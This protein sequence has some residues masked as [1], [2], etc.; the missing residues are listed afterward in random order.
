[1]SLNPHL[2]AITA[3]EI[4][5]DTLG[6][7]LMESI[8]RVDPEARFIGIGGPKMIKAGMVS[9]CD[10]K[11]LSVMGIT[12]VLSH[13]VPILKVRNKVCKLIIK[14]RPCV[15][16]GIDSPDFNLTLERRVRKSGIP[17]VHY[18]SPSVWAWREGR[19]KT[20]RQSCDEVLCL[21][22]FEKDFYD[23]KGMAATYVGHALANSIPISTKMETSRERVDLYRTSV[24][25]I[26]GRVMGILPGSRNGVIEH[27]LPVYAQAA[28]IIKQ[29]SPTTVF[30]STV[31]TYELAC[32]V[33]DL[34]LA[35]AP[36][37]SITVY[38]GSTRDVIASCDCL[39]LTSGTIALET[40]LINRP[41][42]VA[43]K[44]S[45]L[46]AAIGRRM[47]R[48]STYSLPNLIANT[49]LVKE[50]IQEDCTP[51]ALASEMLQLLSS[52]NLVL[53]KQFEDLHKQM[54]LP[55]DDMAA[56]AVLKVARRNQETEIGK[57]VSAQELESMSI[58]SVHEPEVTLP[59]NGTVSDLKMHKSEPSF[60]IGSSKASV[61][62]DSREPK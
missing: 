8:K 59:E 36:D 6:A 1:M 49:T 25:K 30:V 52:D 10:I 31:P 35:V 5:G 26:N 19:V 15:M 60:D 13:I 34:W 3:G 47:L 55:S 45:A 38:V 20:I 58:D 4:S 12:E 29:K 43:Y 16:V 23:K 53:R 28:R 62:P 46:T 11:V 14:E 41:F 24:E 51:E 42:C 17:T 22:K 2:Y 21:L 33:K 18:V 54:C 39:L 44:V 61:E 50:L 7:G 56:E 32:K 57:D 9:C 37:L 27:M 48:I 40:M